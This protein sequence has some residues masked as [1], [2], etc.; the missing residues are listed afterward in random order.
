MMNNKT[1]NT[2]EEIILQ[3]PSIGNEMIQ[4]AFYDSDVDQYITDSTEIDL[5]K[6]KCVEVSKNNDVSVLCLEF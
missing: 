6:S 4:I 1:T 5:I 3:I 2:C